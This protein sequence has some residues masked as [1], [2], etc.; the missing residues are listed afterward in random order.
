MVVSSL[1]HL[2]D[3][4]LSTPVQT[5]PPASTQNG[6]HPLLFYSPLHATVAKA[7]F[8]G[9]DD[10]IKSPA[11]VHVDRVAGLCMLHVGFS[12]TLVHSRPGSLFL[13]LPS[14]FLFNPTQAAPN[15]QRLYNRWCRTEI[16]NRKHSQNVW[17]PV[18]VKT[19][20][21]VSMLPVSLT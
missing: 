16:R 21:S 2:R 3:G 5:Q 11:D 20:H 19:P 17:M 14:D 9:R 8:S 15:K 10:K 18:M 6:S 1:S 4:R 7:L 12:E 13:P